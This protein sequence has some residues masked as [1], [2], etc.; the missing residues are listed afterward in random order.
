MHSKLV[1][2][3]DRTGTSF[4]EL[5][6]QEERI[7]GIRGV[8][9]WRIRRRCCLYGGQQQPVQRTCQGWR[10]RWSDR[11]KRRRPVEGSLF[12]GR[13]RKWRSTAGVVQSFCQGFIIF[14]LVCKRSTQVAL[15]LHLAVKSR[16]TMLVR[17]S[18]DVLSMFCARQVAVALSVNSTVVV[19]AR[20]QTLKKLVFFRCCLVF[21]HQCLE[22]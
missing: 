15:W 14:F 11:R 18:E 6:D 21:Q 17:N 5:A 2:F 12:C 9:C 19:L 8:L 10:C 1:H 3:N 13:A 4:V 22:V 16:Y 7:G 20:L